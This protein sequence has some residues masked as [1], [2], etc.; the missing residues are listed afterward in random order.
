MQDRL[1]FLNIRIT[2]LSDYL[3]ISRPTLYKY[4]D[5]YEKGNRDD[6]N[7][8]LLSFFDY[9]NNT[10][11]IGKKNVISYIINNNPLS[12]DENIESKEETIRSLFGTFEKSR[13]YS[14]E[15]ARFIINVIEN[16]MLDDVIPYLNKCHDVYSKK[17]LNDSDYSLLSS[18][19]LFKDGVF[20][21]RRPTAHKIKKTKEI[22]A[23]EINGEED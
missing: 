11:S 10:P 17:G 20:K 18:F 2:E 21:A 6:L 8:G 9:I 16:S 1:K 4:M 7:P 12:V 13:G 19:V 14:D 5:L 23:G 22:M 15:K 3:Q